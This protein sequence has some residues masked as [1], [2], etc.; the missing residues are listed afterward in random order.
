[1]VEEGEKHRRAY[2]FDSS[3]IFEAV[4]DMGSGALPLLEGQYTI[5]LAYYEL[6]N[7]IWKHRKTIEADVVL[8]ALNDVISTMKVV[9]VKLDREVMEEAARDGITYY[10][11]S[12]LVTSTRVNA[13]LVTLDEE[14]LRLGAKDL[15]EML[16]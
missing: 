3:A 5:N 15:R 11:A 7:V 16:R 1:M 8:D 14:L 10:D 9:D 13:T 2:L 6:G 12:Y 4:M